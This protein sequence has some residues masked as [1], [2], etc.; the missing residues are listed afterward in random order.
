MF[1]KKVFLYNKWMFSGMVFFIIMQ[2]F[3]FYKQG[4]VF[5]PWHNYGMYSGKSHPQKKY[6]V[7]TLS[8]K[9]S[10]GI[11]FFS[12]YREDKLFLAL[13]MFHNQESNNLFFYNSVKRIFNKIHFEPSSLYF[14]THVSETDFQKWFNQYANY[15]I[16]PS[17]NGIS[18]YSG[19]A[20]WDGNML[21]LVNSLPE[22]AN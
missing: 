14:T 12:P 16:Y 15:W 13:A 6:E 18:T 7:Y 3:C 2:L 21:N 20:V 5:S 11:R 22:G 19:T 9:H 4:M 8:Y 1:L 10:S 17:N